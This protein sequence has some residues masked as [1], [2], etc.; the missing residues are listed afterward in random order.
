[1][2]EVKLAK[3]AL[4]GASY[5]TGF[6][7]SAFL[8]TFHDDSYTHQRNFMLKCFHEAFQSLPSGLSVLDYGTGPTLC[9]AIS[10][11]TKA[12]E[13][14]LSDYTEANRS[15][16]RQWL[17]E[18]PTAYDWSPYFDYV[19]RELEGR[20]ESEVKERQ[21]MVRNAVKA[22]VH[23]DLSQDCPIEEGFDRQYDVVTSSLCVCA[24][25]QTHEEYRQGFAKLGKL[26]KPGGTM[27][28]YEAE[29]IKNCIGVYPV[30]NTNFRYVGV[31][32]EFAV[33]ALKDAGFTNITVQR[34]TIAPNLRKDSP[35]RT[36]YIFLMGT[37]I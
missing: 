37:K 2:T 18:D 22:V 24:A 12:S 8:R 34:T 28:I 9:L 15:A 5:H 20:E 6:D 29:R 30:E 1:M 31:T 16:L 32:S 17:N 25:V 3:D 36:G 14:V 27:M 4:Y 7:T 11:V 33:Q 35:D 21:K 26:V 19:V 13:I 10:S 23:C